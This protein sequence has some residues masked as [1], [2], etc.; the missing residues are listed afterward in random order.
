LLRAA[1]FP[2]EPQV[3]EEGDLAQ[4]RVVVQA[5]PRPAFE[6]VEAEFPLHLSVHLLAHPAGL[7]GLGEHP[8]RSV[9]LVVGQVELALARGA[10][11]ALSEKHSSES[12]MDAAVGARGR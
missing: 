10:L 8:E 2:A 5:A 1:R 4:E 6:M 3:L 9:S 11:L 12:C 7:D